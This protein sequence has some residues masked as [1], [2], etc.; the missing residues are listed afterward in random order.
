MAKDIIK[1][2]D[3]QDG[4]DALKP[5]ANAYNL[6]ADM[7]SDDLPIFGKALY[8][9]AA[10][11]IGIVAPGDKRASPVAVVFTDHP[12]GYLQMQVRQVHAPASDFDPTGILVLH[13]NHTKT[14]D[15]V[16]GES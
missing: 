15:T 11:T 8:L 2:G 3:Y 1:E 14:G 4:A 16:P 13:D 10:M 9:P 7:L 6:T 5:A 12:A